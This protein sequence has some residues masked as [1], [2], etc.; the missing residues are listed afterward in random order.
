MKYQIIE[1][2]YNIKKNGD[3]ILQ[4]VGKYLTIKQYSEL[5]KSKQE[6]CSL[7]GKN[8]DLT[9]DHAYELVSAYCE[10]I[11]TDE[12]VEGFLF[13]YPEYFAAQGITC[14]LRII[15][16]R[17]N[18]N[19]QDS[20]L[21]NPGAALESAMMDIDSERFGTDIESKLDTLLSTI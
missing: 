6:K 11:D 17:D 9:Y 3:A 13:N 2:F 4:P 12:I 16:G 1:S 15:A 21:S 14:Q 10:G 18:N 7:V 5:T 8:P 20:G 19:P